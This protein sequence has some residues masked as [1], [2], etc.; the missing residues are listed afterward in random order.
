MTY[1]E[2][3]TVK[4]LGGNIGGY[5]SDIRVGKDFLNKAQKSINCKGKITTFDYVNIKNFLSSNVTI[6]KMKK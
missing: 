1:I 6:N 2:D 5:L 4:L 3:K